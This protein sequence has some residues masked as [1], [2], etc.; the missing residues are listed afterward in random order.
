MNIIREILDRDNNIKFFEDMV[1]KM[2]YNTHKKYIHVEYTP[3]VIEMFY[4]DFK[5]N[6]KTLRAFS[7]SVY[8]VKMYSNDLFTNITVHIKD[9]NT[10]KLYA[11]SFKLRWW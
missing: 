2:Y 1:Q 4:N 5:E 3:I 8:N 9:E 11:I 6:V 7:Y 10:S